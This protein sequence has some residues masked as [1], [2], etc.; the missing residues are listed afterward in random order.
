MLRTP[1]KD[2]EG[3]PRMMNPDSSKVIY[4][5]ASVEGE[6]HM[7]THNRKMKE[8]KKK[9]TPRVN[10]FKKS[11][12]VTKHGS[13]FAKLLESTSELH[14]DMKTSEDSGEPLLQ[15][16]LPLSTNSIKGNFYHLGGKIGEF[17]DQKKQTVTSDIGWKW[18]K[19]ILGQCACIW[20]K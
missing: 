11:D 8:I 15:V 14:R 10:A 2:G 12:R 4:V 7:I 17:L 13:F 19:K 6:F 18:G 3:E 1:K 20:C 16:P 5:T 9:I